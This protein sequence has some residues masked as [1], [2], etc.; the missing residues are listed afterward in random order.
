MSSFASRLSEVAK[1]RR[2]SPR[3]LETRLRPSGFGEVR[4]AHL[5]QGD[6]SPKQKTSP[7][8]AR[9]SPGF[10]AQADKIRKSKEA[11]A[12]F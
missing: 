1:L 3:F 7:I 6:I 10:S 4:P 11:R 5:F 9:A 2:T 12:A 8:H